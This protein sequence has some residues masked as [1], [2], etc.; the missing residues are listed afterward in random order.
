MWDR[1]FGGP[2]HAWKF[3]RNILLSLRELRGAMWI[4]GMF[5]SNQ[6]RNQGETDNIS[7]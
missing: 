6:P 2:L 7:G 3:L 1:H 4:V 5:P